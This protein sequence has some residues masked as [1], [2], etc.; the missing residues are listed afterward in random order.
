[1]SAQVAAAPPNVPLTPLE[2]Q[3]A[4]QARDEARQAFAERRY[5][6]AFRKAHAA[7]VQTTGHA[8]D[9]ELLQSEW[10]IMGRIEFAEESFADARADFAQEYAALRSANREASEEAALN[11]QR[12]AATFTSEDNFVAAEA[13]LS[14]AL[15]L[16]RELHG[17]PALLASNLADVA[18]LFAQTSRAEQARRAIAEGL[19]LLKP[20]SEADD[21]AI[22]QLQMAL[23]ALELRDGD[24]ARSAA[25]FSAAADAAGRHEQSHAVEELDALQ[26]LIDRQNRLGQFRKSIET[27]E[28]ALHLDQ[29]FPDAESPR[30]EIA[31]G[32]ISSAAAM[33]DSAQVRRLLVQYH[34][35]SRA[36]HVGSG[37]LEDALPPQGSVQE[38]Q[39]PPP[40]E[41]EPPAEAA[42]I[43]RNHA[44]VESLR[45]AFKAC[46]TASL[47]TPPTTTGSLHLKLTLQK[48]GSVA[49]LS[50][51]AVALPVSLVDCVLTKAATSQFDPRND[52]HA[53]ITVPITFKP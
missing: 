51:F 50:A 10:E 37:V 7:L 9:P 3:A 6:E 23:A 17:N 31:L 47:A 5:D 21:D 13:P 27:G 20:G 4:E 24:D 52:E 36:L 28:R 19:A 40:H 49:E 33:G 39:K 18:H 43:A 46:Y 32:L 26:R 34:G 38:H 1:V 44:V 53:V 25:A 16:R 12:T 41:P 11:L 22:Y 42:L 48:G 8:V 45:P 30:S 2:R 35:A 14:R 15:R 29:R